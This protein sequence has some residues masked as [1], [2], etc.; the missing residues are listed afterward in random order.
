ME[1]YAAK[2]ILHT[3]YSFFPSLSLDCDG[4]AAN[5]GVHTLPP[6]SR[7]AQNSCVRTIEWALLFPLKFYSIYDNLLLFGSVKITVGIPIGRRRLAPFRHSAQV[8]S[9]IIS[10]KILFHTFFLFL[11]GRF[12]VPL[13]L[14]RHRRQRPS[15]GI[16]LIEASEGK[17][18]AE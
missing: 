2:S 17:C 11:S 3:L 16:R 13:L 10:F 8:P 15:A 6:S 7:H 18:G 9:L 1:K 5:S 14:P 12:A 4:I